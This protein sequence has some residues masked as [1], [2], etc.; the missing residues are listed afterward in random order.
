MQV[1]HAHEEGICDRC[2]AY[3]DPEAWIFWILDGELVP[4][5]ELEAK[6]EACLHDADEHLLEVICETCVRPVINQIFDSLMVKGILEP[7]YNDKEGDF[8]YRLTDLG[9]EVA[10]EIIRQEDD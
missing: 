3:Q 9:R 8:D 10:G 1:E 5:E 6:L 7:R 4:N 2:H